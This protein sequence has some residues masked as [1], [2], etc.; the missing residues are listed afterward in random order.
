MLEMSGLRKGVNTRRQGV[1]GAML[2][3]AFHIKSQKSGN[4]PSSWFSLSHSLGLGPPGPLIYLQS[5]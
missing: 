4:V 2:D 1:L 5:G 3:S